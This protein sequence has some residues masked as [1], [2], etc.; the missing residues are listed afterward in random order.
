MN[1]QYIKE[2]V[3]FV[4]GFKGAQYFDWLGLHQALDKP[5]KDN[6]LQR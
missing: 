5:G 4:F 6:L 3:W 2:G 1:A